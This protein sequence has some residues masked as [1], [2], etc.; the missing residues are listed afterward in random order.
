MKD[1]TFTNTVELQTHGIHP[2]PIYLDTPFL[3]LG[4]MVRPAR[5]KNI[6][7]VIQ[8][9]AQPTPL[10]WVYSATSY[11]NGKAA[12]VQMAPGTTMVRTGALVPGIHDWGPTREPE[13]VLTS[14]QGLQLAIDTLKNFEDEYS[15]VRPI[16]ERLEKSLNASQ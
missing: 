7:L 14:Q 1:G 4:D 3:R 2:A 5:I 6:L 12:I 9:R 11:L 15:D 10:G 8:S 13:S 16:I